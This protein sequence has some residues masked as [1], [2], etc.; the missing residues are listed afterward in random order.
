MH[1]LAEPVYFRVEDA[2]KHGVTE[3]ILLMNL[4]YWIRTNRSTDPDYQFHE[5]SP[6]NLATVLPY[7]ES[8][9]KRALKH[10]TDEDVGVLIARRPSDGRCASEYR[11]ADKNLLQLLGPDQNAGGSDQD[12]QKPC[13]NMGGTYL[14]MSG[15]KANNAGPETNVC[16][17]KLDNNTI[18]IDNH[19]EDTCLEDRKLIT[20]KFESES[21]SETFSQDNGSNQDRVSTTTLAAPSNAFA[22]PIAG[23]AKIGVDANLS[24]LA[25][26]ARVGTNKVPASASNSAA[27]L[28]ATSSLPSFQSAQPYRLFLDPAVDRQNLD[29]VIKLSSIKDEDNLNIQIAHLAV[30]VIGR[31]AKQTRPEELLYFVNLPNQKEQDLALIQWATSFFQGFMSSIIHDQNV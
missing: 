1:N 6:H 27:P 26:L 28:P 16:G 24:A 11:F 29:L 4:A 19:F 21:V 15:P 3:A 8:T 7:S 25:P 13:L 14:D 30:E 9:L 18:L 10:L 17:P 20:K 31:L 12:S 2:E 22:E 5:M 23:D